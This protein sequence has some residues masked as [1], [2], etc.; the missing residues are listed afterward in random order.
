MSMAITVLGGG[1]TGLST[2]WYLAQRLPSTVAIRLIEGSS[3]LGGW[4]R[5][6]KRQSGGTSFIAEKGPRTL[7]TG[8]SREALAVLE[9]VD[10]LG[11]RSDVVMAPKLSA[12]ARN[13][14]IY[15]GGEL[16]CMP[17]GLGSLITG[18][19]PAVRCLPKGIWHDLTT[20]KNA[21]ADSSDESI[22]DFVSRRFGQ[23]V[24]DNLSSAVMH[25]IYATDTKELSARA[26]LYPFWLADHT[27][28][29]GVLRGL[30]R[31]AKLSRARN[32]QFAVRDA[33]ERYLITK[34]R[35]QNPEFWESINDASM[36]SFRD[37]MQTLTDRL[38]S[39]LSAFPNVEIITGQPAMEA[40]LGEDGNAEIQ[41]A[42]STVVRAQHVINTLP[43]HH[44]RSLF[45]GGPSNALLDDTPYA[46]VAVVNVTYPKKGITP[47]DGFGYLVPRASSGSSKALGV[48]FDSCT[49]PAQD[50][51]ADISRLSVMLGGSRFRELFGAPGS[52]SKSA[53]ED[54]AIDTIRAHLG[55]KT[56][57]ADIDATVGENCIPSYTVGYV[58]KLKA[59]HEWVQGQLGG[60]MSVVGAAY[61]GPAVPQCI[62]HARDLV[63]R[64]LNLDSL[65]SPQGVTGLEEIIGGFN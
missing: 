18:L 34:R 40:R 51:G 9:L 5:T 54:V 14:Y 43:L 56:T 17:T 63:N 33:E 30:R 60:R 29:T 38:A 26:L 36:Y 8:H 62:V 52:A 1:V 64:Q 31:V 59:M 12:A 39:R 58:D 41:L 48:V 35:M 50:G 65:E 24:D 4:V 3:R 42:D 20:K 23:Q 19:P 10:D 16:N 47:V 53:L 28:K 37:G 32:A 61:G 55:I 22:H 49:L 7:R 27:G 25:G 44:V 11:L 13:R 57:P 21:P 2:A 6:D 45:A 46:S 15:Y